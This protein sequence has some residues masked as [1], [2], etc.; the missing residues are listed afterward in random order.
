MRRT[1]FGLAAAAALALA[2]CGGDDGDSSSDEGDET[3][4]TTEGSETTEAA[5][6][7]GGSG[8]PSS[9]EAE[10]FCE[11]FEELT[12]QG[13]DESADPEALI[14]SMSAIEPPPEIAE[15]FELTIEGARLQAQMQAQMAEGDEEPDP[16]AMAQ[17]QERSQDYTEANGRV[18]QYVTDECG[19]GGAPAPDSGSG[20]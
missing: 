20:G 15:D 16:E 8:S 7:D 13:T 1:V 17:F 11:E 9:P 14:D 10:R 2:A 18:Q 4:E 5:A 3:T 19:L 12:E 6:G